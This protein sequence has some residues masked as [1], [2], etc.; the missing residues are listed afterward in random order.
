MRIAFMG[1]PDFSVECLKALVGSE[2][3]VVGVFCQPDK[4]VGRKQILTPPDVKVEA[5][6]HNLEIF[7]PESL[8]GGKGVEILKKIKP[9]LIIV[10]AYGKILPKDFL[11]FPKYGCINIHASILPKYRGAS[12]IHFAVL[13]GDKIT[14]V[15]AMQMDEGLDT[16][17]ILNV[18]TIEI[19]ENDTTEYMYEVM[20]PLGAKVLMDTINLLEQGKLSPVK[21]D[22]SKA[23]KVGLLSKEMSTID[24]SLSAFEIHNKIRGLYSW[25]CASTALNGKTL[26]IHSSVICDRKGNNNP[27]E[28]IEAQ[29]KLIV[30]CGDNNCIELKEVQLEGKKRMDSASFLNGFTDLKGVVLGK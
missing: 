12:P 23:S 8:R 14:G 25:P 21:Q 5:L 9:D 2:H 3:E 4:P 20:A 18:G 22:D 26:K 13:N 11:E 1:T 27:G 17:D 30:S 24:W 10:V 7:Q 16:G 19:G 6:K 15:T 28:V 29:K